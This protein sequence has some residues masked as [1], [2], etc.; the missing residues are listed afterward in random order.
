MILFKR[1]IVIIFFYRTRILSVAMLVTNSL[2]H[3]LTPL[4]LLH[5]YTLTILHSYTFTLLLSSQKHK[6]YY[7]MLIANSLGRN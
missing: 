4:T 6:T 5:S 2:T 7:K 3:S 1:K